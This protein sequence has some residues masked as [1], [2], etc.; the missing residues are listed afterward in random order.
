MVLNDCINEVMVLTL[1]SKLKEHQ[2]IKQHLKKYGMDPVLYKVT[3][4]STKKNNGKGTLSMSQILS[5]N[6]PDEVSMDIYKNHIMMIQEAYSKGYDRVLF[7]EDDA[8][9]EDKLDPIQIQ[10]IKY[11]LKNKEWD[12][13]YLGYCPWPYVISFP[14]S[15]NIVRIPS[16]LL[17]HAYIL[18]RSGMEKI[19]EHHNSTVLPSKQNVHMDKVLSEIKGFYKLGTYPSI[20]YQKNDPG[21]FKEA[22]NK[23]KLPFGFK[24]VCKFLEHFAL[25]WPIL[26]LLIVIF[27]IVRYYF[28]KKT[29]QLKASL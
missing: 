27:L 2:E 7:L 5:H 6:A 10:N 25:L 24:K 16:P 15:P 29:K 28:R 17:A 13:F 21:L 12:I 18:S 23:M 20:C 9:F 4:I 3:G 11:V 1:E 22:K 14:V 8:R 26:V 19:L